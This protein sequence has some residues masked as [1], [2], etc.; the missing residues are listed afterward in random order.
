[1]AQSVPRLPHSQRWYS[2]YVFNYLQHKYA[3]PENIHTRRKDSLI[4]R[5]SR[6]ACV[7]HSLP[8]SDPGPSENKATPRVVIG[9]S[10]GEGVSKAKIFKGKLE[11]KLEIPAERGGGEGSK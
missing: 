10:K 9:N 3:V 2:I 7:T 6:V 11:A 5:P 1:M 8:T 4:L